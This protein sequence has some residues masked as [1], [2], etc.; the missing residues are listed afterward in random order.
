MHDADPAGQQ[1]VDQLPTD[2]RVAAVVVL[3]VVEGHP[4]AP[5]VG[6]IRS[7]QERGIHH[8]GD[9][10]RGPRRQHAAHLAQHARR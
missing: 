4:V 10:H 1:Q 7:E 9:V 3:E 2:D 6:R 8:L 5:D